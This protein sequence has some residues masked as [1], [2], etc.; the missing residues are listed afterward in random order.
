MRQYKNLKIWERSVD[1]A[2]LV[3][4]ITSDFPKSEIYG[5]TSQLRRCSVSISSNIAEGAARSSDKE[6]QRFLDIAYGSCY[7]LQSQLF[8]AFKLNLLNK[9]QFKEMNTEMD[10]IPKMIFTFSKTL[11]RSLTTHNS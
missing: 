4:K 5:L 6:F 10:E 11:N 8:I 3:Y 7:E 1:L 9:S 2:L